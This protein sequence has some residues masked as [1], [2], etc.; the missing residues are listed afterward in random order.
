VTDVSADVV[1][2]MPTP[3]HLLPNAALGQM[4]Y[5]LEQLI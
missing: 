2:M 4:S 1:A 3:N 5:N